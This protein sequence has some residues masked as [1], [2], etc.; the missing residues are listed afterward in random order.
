SQ[1]DVVGDTRSILEPV[2]LLQAPLEDL[3]H[4]EDNQCNVSDPLSGTMP[5]SKSARTTTLLPVFNQ[6]SYKRT[7]ARGVTPAACVWNTSAIS[8]SSS[9]N[10]WKLSASSPKMS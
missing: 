6:R 5:R 8:N 4:L 9:A 1:R 3:R 10:S 2:Q 7:V